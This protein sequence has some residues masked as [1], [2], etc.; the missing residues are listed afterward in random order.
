MRLRALAPALAFL[1]LACDPTRPDPTEIRT[2]VSGN[3]FSCAL[4]GERA[5]CWGRNDF[6]QLGRGSIGLDEAA[7]EVISSP[8]F[9]L[10]AAGER[11][12]CGV[13]TD[14][15]VMCWGHGSITGGSAH[16]ASPTQMSPVP[17]SIVSIGVGQAHACVLS[18]NGAATCFGSNSLA[19]VGN[20]TNQPTTGALGMTAVVGGHV[21]SQLAVGAFQN[22]GVENGKLWCW[23]TNFSSVFGPG[24]T[25]N[26]PYGTPAEVVLP[27]APAKVALGSAVSCA[28]DA[29][30]KAWCWGTNLAGQLGRG[31]GTAGSASP[32]PVM[33]SEAFTY[34]SLALPNVN[35]TITH[36]CGV[37]VNGSAVCFGLNDASQLGRVA[38]ETCAVSSTTLVACSAMPAAI[39]TS[40]QFTKLAAGRDHTCGITTAGEIYCWG[41]DLRKQLNGLNGGTT[42]IPVHVVLAP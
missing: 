25:P 33:V 34:T 22:C 8:R 9:R 18:A 29:A 6:G 38:A 11:N 20:G 39:E 30:A 23:G 37:T 15:Q 35:S 19:A 36:T 41:S 10:L 27:F 2:V 4:R 26:A 3:G 13:T 16:L 14:E 21:F 31:V 32:D 5:W 24:T 12:V 40:M 17:A 28:I 7:A 42:R 1:A